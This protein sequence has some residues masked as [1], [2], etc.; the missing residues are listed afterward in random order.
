[1]GLHFIS[2]YKSNMQE[3]PNLE[4]ITELAGDD[5]VFEQKFI[6]I[7]KKE[8]PVEQETYIALMDKSE[9]MEAAEIVHKLKHKFNILSMTASYTFA[10]AYEEELKKSRPQMDSGFR[11]ILNTIGT[12]LKT[13]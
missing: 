1:M 10:V 2:Q 3:K 9:L 7:L 12:Y 11:D 13:I 5:K 4:Y 8:F 6:M